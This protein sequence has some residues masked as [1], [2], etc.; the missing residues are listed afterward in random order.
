MTYYSALMGAPLLIIGFLVGSYTM[1]HWQEQVAR[2]ENSADDDGDTVKIE[3]SEAEM[4][5]LDYMQD[6][7]DSLAPQEEEDI[8][9]EQ[10]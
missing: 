3:Q 2:N 5:Q 7:N 4:D 1:K 8:P 10:V 6:N 9:Q